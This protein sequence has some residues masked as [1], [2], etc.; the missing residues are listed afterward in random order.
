MYSMLKMLFIASKVCDSFERC[1]RPLSGTFIIGCVGNVVIE[2]IRL[3]VIHLLCL[4]LIR[5]QR[6][7]QFDTS[8]SDGC[9]CDAELANRITEK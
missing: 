1:I 7:G 6:H 3:W 4:V 8:Y 5:I 9:V 2:L